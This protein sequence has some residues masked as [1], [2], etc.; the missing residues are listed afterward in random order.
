MGRS[1]IWRVIPPVVILFGETI[2][3][4]CKAKKKA[5]PTPQFAGRIGLFSAW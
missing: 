3:W 4:D 5:D 2:C 1:Q